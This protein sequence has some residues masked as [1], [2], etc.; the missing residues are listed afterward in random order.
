[1]ATLGCGRSPQQ[2]FCA[3]SWLE[4]NTSCRAVR[5]QNAEDALELIPGDVC[6]LHVSVFDG[7]SG[8]PVQRAT[9]VVNNASH[10]NPAFIDWN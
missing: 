2:V 6:P 10:A 8:D 1:M 4:N 7:N 9:V 3:F 5:F